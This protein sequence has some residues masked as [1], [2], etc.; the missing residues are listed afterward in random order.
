MRGLRNETVQTRETEFTVRPRAFR[1]VRPVKSVT[2]TPV[3]SRKYHRGKFTPVTC[4]ARLEKLVTGR[5]RSFGIFS[6][7]EW[8]RERGILRH[9]F[10]HCVSTVMYGYYRRNRRRIYDDIVNRHPRITADEILLG[11]RRSRAKRKMR[12][13]RIRVESATGGP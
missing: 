8:K 13:K 12:R 2:R 1:A 3:R 7:P 5:S 11:C 10:P 9:C 6:K 4:N